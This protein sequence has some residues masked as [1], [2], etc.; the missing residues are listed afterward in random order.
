MIELVYFFFFFQIINFENLIGNTFNVAG[1][2]V[3]TW[4]IYLFYIFTYISVLLYLIGK[5]DS[6]SNRLKIVFFIS[7]VILIHSISLLNNTSV[8]IILRRSYHYVLPVFLYVVL[9][10]CKYR[11][12]SFWKFFK[13][14]IILNTM[15][16]IAFL[17]G[18]LGAIT[19]TS[20]ISMLSRSSTLIDGGL[21]I[22]SLAVGLYCLFYENDFY[23]RKESWLFIV[24]G[25]IITISGQSRARLLTAFLVFITFYFIS[26]IGKNRNTGKRFS[27]LS[28][29]LL[30]ASVII[31]VLIIDGEKSNSILSQIFNRFQLM[32]SD[33]PSIYR[34]YERETQLSV[35][36]E[37]PILGGGWGAYE[38]IFVRDIYGVSKNVN[39]HNMYTTL[40]GYGGI[41]LGLAYLIWFG[42]VI[43]GI[44]KRF[45]SN[46]IEKLNIILL[47][48]IL[49]L[50]YSSAGFGKSSMIL[51]IAIIY[52]N[53]NHY[54]FREYNE[55]W[56]SLK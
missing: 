12:R 8:T 14:L 42:S 51:A 1:F 20:Y 38:E 33:N 56:K 19:N 9:Y 25:V 54:V 37:H 18:L 55:G 31:I 13:I 10:R 30:A 47:I 36:Y 46:Q 15:I 27:W 11:Y 7:V 17:T 24:A 21:G 6:Q 5:S 4:I 16:S 32:G 39:N 48:S 29:G 44:I 2:P 50:S 23:T 53:I 45:Q 26:T 28:A 35:F 22:V 52:V 43:G 49:I 34:V 3:W 41:F 40:L